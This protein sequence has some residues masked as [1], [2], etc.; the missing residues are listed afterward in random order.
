MLRSPSLQILPNGAFIP[1]SFDLSKFSE[2]KSKVA[3]CQKLEEELF[4]KLIRSNFQEISVFFKDRGTEF[5]TKMSF[6]D[7]LLDESRNESIL[8]VAI[9]QAKFNLSKKIISYL[10]NFYVANAKDAVDNN[11]TILHLL[12]RNYDS[13][14]DQI[15]ELLHETINACPELLQATMKM[16]GNENMNPIEMAI[17][18]SYDETLIDLML[19]KA[20]DTLGQLSSE[21]K[22]KLLGR[23]KAL[24]QSGVSTIAQMGNRV[25]K[26]IDRFFNTNTIDK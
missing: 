20:R 11:M 4:K 18:T 3:R 17:V 26:K 19:T 8:E 5:L 9:Q 23:A 21:D 16:D 15:T 25:I 1:S 2:Y 12:V 10:F 7:I 24:S 14:K 22:T 6:D 13:P